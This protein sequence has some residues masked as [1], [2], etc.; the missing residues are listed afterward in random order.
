MRIIGLIDQESQAKLFV[1][2]LL[3]EGIEAQLEH[4]TKG[5]EIWV[6]SE[7]HVERAKIEIGIFNLN[8][9][10]PKYKDATQRAADVLKSRLARQKQYER[11]VIIPNRSLGTTE[12]GPLTITLIVICAGV[13]LATNFGQYNSG[14]GSTIKALAFTSVAPPRSFE[15]RKASDGGE[16]TLNAKLESIKNWEFWRLVTPVFLHFGAM[17]LVFNMVMLFQLGRLIETRYSSG[18][19]AGLVL[20]TA[21]ISNL[22]Q[23]AVPDSWGGSDP[24]MVQDNLIMLLGG[25][26]GVVYGLFGFVWV[27][28]VIDPNSNFNISQVF[29]VIMIAWLFICMTPWGDNA[30]GSGNGHGSIANWAHAVGLFVGMT[31]GYLA[32][33]VRRKAT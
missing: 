23:V 28:S 15:L 22:G 1:A 24:S 18:T 12:R 8:P 5:F 10:D 13:A 6:K 31:A 29:V 27:K 2:W 20:L 11:N 19:L 26:S 33:V 7:D 16:Y 14:I 32:T 9:Q 21:T 30:L 3:A 17:H 4:E 25:M